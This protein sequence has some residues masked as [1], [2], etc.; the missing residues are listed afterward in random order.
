MNA[1][2]TEDLHFSWYLKILSIIKH[3]VIYTVSYANNFWQLRRRNSQAGVILGHTKRELLRTKLG[4]KRLKGPVNK[5]LE[6]FSYLFAKLLCNI[7]DNV[8]KGR[9]IV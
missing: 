8:D 2:A 9:K 3:S 1:S 7:L 4:R 5:L 6:D